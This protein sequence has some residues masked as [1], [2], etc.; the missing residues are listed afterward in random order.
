MRSTYK[1]LGVIA[2]FLVILALLAINTAILRHQLAVQVGI[3][4]G[5]ATAGEQQ[6]LMVLRQQSVDR[7]GGS[8]Y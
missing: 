5:L 8:G 3:R 6:S 7:R 1:R 2:G 4:S